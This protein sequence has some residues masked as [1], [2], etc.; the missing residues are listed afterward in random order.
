MRSI[1]D[2]RAR[3]REHEDEL[4]SLHWF[5]PAELGT[6]WRLA[7]STVREIPREKLRY[8]EFGSGARNKRRRYR[9][10]WV[11]AYE[12]AEGM[13]PDVGTVGTVGADETATA[14]AG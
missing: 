1:D 5:T 9:A 12:E 13:T 6:R 11:L 2:I 7:G 14:R 4:L 3:A 8:K 10:D